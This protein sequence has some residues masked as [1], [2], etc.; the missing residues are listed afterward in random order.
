M[1][2][3][4]FFIKTIK[5]KAREDVKKLDKERKIDNLKPFVL[6]IKKIQ[7]ITN[8]T[9]CFN[10]FTKR[11]FK[12]TFVLKNMDT[13]RNF[14]PSLRQNSAFIYFVNLLFSSLRQLN[15]KQEK[16]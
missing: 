11:K 1:N 16:M 2:L 7:Y 4:I 10:C 15:I 3:Y 9:I 14:K 12:H 6:F 8:K 5:N 13:C